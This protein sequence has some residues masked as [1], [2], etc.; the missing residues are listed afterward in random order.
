MIK[1]APAPLGPLAGQDPDVLV[2]VVTFNSAAVIE[3]F[4]RAAPMALEGVGTASVVVVDNASD[5]ATT[6][7]VRAVAPWATVIN[8]GANRGYASGINTA[9]A[10][11]TARR[12]VYV[13]NPD[14]IPSPGSAALLA[15]AV[16]D[17][18]GV[19][20]AVPRIV[21][22]RGELMFSLRREPTIRR[23]LGEA[24][25]GGTRAS[26]LSWASE[27]IGDADRYV[28]GA[29]ADWATGAAMFLSARAVDAT[30]G[31][32][33]AFFLYSEE[34]DYALRVRDAG[35]RVSLVAAAEVSHKG[36][37]LKES[38]WLWSLAAVNRVRLY[39]ARHGAGLGHLYHLAVMV[40]EA[41]RTPTRRL[42]H[43]AAVKGLLRGVR[44]P[45]GGL[46]SPHSPT[47][48]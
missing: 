20:I 3:H 24:I 30:A 5:D 19:G 33:E 11:T 23:A 45:S 13:L 22:E 28:D 25:L 37:D 32:N 41:L 47:D 17:R 29:T 15:D 46:V 26:R 36:G 27:I 34:T 2:A 35:L 21:S 40:N 4:L 14:T 31:W 7:L 43:R 38:P 42:T 39:R 48:K 6:S 16:E 12:G 44:L 9:M 1:P 18:P 8:T 10:H